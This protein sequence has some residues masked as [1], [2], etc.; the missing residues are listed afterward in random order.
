MLAQPK[1]RYQVFFAVAAAGLNGWSLAV[2]FP[3]WEPCLGAGPWWEVFG[4]ARAEQSPAMQSIARAKLRHALP[5]LS[6]A[7]LCRC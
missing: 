3:L 7:L 6:L 4:Y 1:R 2:R 5:L